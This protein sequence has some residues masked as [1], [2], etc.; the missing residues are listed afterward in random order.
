MK[1]KIW[2]GIAL[3]LAIILAINIFAF[4]LLPNYAKDSSSIS[5][6]ITTANKNQSSAAIST[7]SDTSSTL[8]SDTSTQTTPSS[9]SQTTV[10]PAQQPAPTPMPSR[11]ITRAS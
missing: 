4:G 5:A 11:R 3:V 9:S 1:V 6:N 2:V 8:T 7:T 10:Q